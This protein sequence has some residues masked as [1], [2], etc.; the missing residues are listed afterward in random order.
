MN[1]TPRLTTLLATLAIALGS[2]CANADVS[3]RWSNIAAE[4]SRD[5]HE[6]PAVAER[7][8]A[9]VRKAMA[10]AGAAGNGNG[11]GNAGGKARAE[12]R[13]AAVAVAAFAVL[14]T[15]YPAQRESLEAQLAVTLSYVPETSAK[16]Q[17]AAEGRRMAMEVMR[18][19]K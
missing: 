19:S 10:A 6:A 5:A 7:N 11:N 2:T 1:K 14:E 16:A 18:T 4:T 8:I 17:G 12:R 15:L 13:D 3:A 9:A